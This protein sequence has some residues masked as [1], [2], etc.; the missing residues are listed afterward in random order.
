MSDDFRLGDRLRGWSRG[1]GRFAA[2]T[3]V[4][5]ISG[6][7]A[8]PESGRQASPDRVDVPARRRLGRLTER[9]QNLQPRGSETLT[10]SNNIEPKWR[11]FSI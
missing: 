11:H 4:R 1:F 5:S 7:K 10:R 2:A 3:P 8:N 6:R 9:T